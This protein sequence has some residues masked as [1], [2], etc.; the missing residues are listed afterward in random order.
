LWKIKITKDVTTR[1]DFSARRRWKCAYGRSFVL[2]PT[3]KN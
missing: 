2:G 1:C 3:R